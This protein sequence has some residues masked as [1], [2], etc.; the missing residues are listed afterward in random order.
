VPVN[1]SRIAD[2]RLGL[3]TYGV[4]DLTAIYCLRA[5]ADNPWVIDRPRLIAEHYEPLPKV[6]VTDFGSEPDVARKA[7]D[8]CEQDGP[9]YSHVPDHVLHSMRRKGVRRC[10]SRRDCNGA[11]AT[12]LNRGVD[13]T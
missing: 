7:R 9:G 3:I 4:S 13:R 12:Q 11:M 2:D 8:I 1:T 5:H 6:Q 10:L